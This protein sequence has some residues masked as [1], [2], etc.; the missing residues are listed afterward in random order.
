MAAKHAAQDRAKWAYDT[1]KSFRGGNEKETKS[2]IRKLPSHIQT[3][4]LA[5]TLLFY[6]N[7]Q[8][9]IAN[10][11]RS[12]LALQGNDIAAAVQDLVK[13]PARFRLKTREAMSAAQW[14]KRFAEVMLEG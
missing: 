7:K 12:H 11:L 5:Q 3:S 6:G 4:G 14:L 13:D 9:E 10:A 1:V 2:H 8:K